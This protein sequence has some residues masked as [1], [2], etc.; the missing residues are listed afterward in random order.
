MFWFSEKISDK[1]NFQSYSIGIVVWRELLGG[2]NKQKLRCTV[3]RSLNASWPLL[4][5]ITVHYNN[6]DYLGRSLYLFLPSGKKQIPFWWSQ[7]FYRTP[8]FLYQFSQGPKKIVPTPLKSQLS[9]HPGHRYEPW[10]S[11]VEFKEWASAH[12]PSG[13]AGQH[14]LLFLNTCS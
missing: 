5:K 6:G 11:S 10:K 2:F 13:G 14:H 9:R 4:T 7:A 1:G 12:K 3:D 8:S